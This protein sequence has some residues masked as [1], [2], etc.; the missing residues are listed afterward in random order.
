MLHRLWIVGLVCTA[1]LASCVGGA[2]VS[3]STPFISLP[4]TTP[5]QPISPP[6]ADEPTD[7]QPAVASTAESDAPPIPPGCTVVSKQFSA[8]PTQVSLFPAVTQAD[9]SIGPANASV[10]IVEYGDFQ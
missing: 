1:L 3:P 8:E 7:S 9:W 5:T 2:V 10:T 4:Q 6:L